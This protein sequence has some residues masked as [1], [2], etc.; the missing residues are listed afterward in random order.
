MLA[1]VFDSGNSSLTFEQQ[2]AV[3]V[4]RRPR[5]GQN[6]ESRDLLA[7]ASS[8]QILDKC[9]NELRRLSE[10]WDGHDADALSELTLKNARDLALMLVAHTRM[11]QIIPGPGDT[12]TLE[13]ESAVGEALMEV[14]HRTYSF[15]MKTDSGRKTTDTG[16]LKQ[17]GDIAALGKLVERELFEAVID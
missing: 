7:E 15:L 5:F 16:R 9:M 6:T 12:L 13:W 1:P 8:R 4:W 11:P 10:G 2:H 14:G 3:A 17:V